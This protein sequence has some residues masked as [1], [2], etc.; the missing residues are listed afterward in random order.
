MGGS[1]ARGPLFSVDMDGPEQGKTQGRKKPIKS[2]G[3]YRIREKSER[4]FTGIRRRPAIGFFIMVG[5]V[6][7]LS[8]GSLCMAADE[9]PLSDSDPEPDDMIRI[10]ASEEMVWDAATDEVTAGEDVVI[11]RS[12]QKMT[13]GPVFLNLSTNEAT[14]TDGIRI[15]TEE[16]EFSGRQMAFNIDDETETLSAGTIYD[17]HLFYKKNHIHIRGQ[18]ITKTGEDTYEGQNV[19]VTSCEGES[20]AWEIGG[21]NFKVTYG[22]YG[23]VSHAFFRLHEVPVLY[24][25]FFVFPIKLERQT[26]LL[27]PSFDY[28][29]RKG[30]MMSQPFFW[31]INES[32]DATFYLDYMTKR[33]V[34]I[35]TEYRY[36][37]TDT[38]QGMVLFDF[39]DDRKVDDGTGTWGY[40]SDG[41]LRTNSDRYWFRMKH[42]QSL[43]EQSSL[44]LDLDIVSDQDYLYE[45]K[46]GNTGYVSTNARFLDTFGR[47]IDSYDETVRKNRLNYTSQWVGYSFTAE[48]IWRDNII[49]RT[50]EDTDDT[51]DPVQYLPTISFDRYR[52]SL[53]GSP[54]YAGFETDAAY[55]YH[56]DGISGERIDLNPRL[57]LPWNIGNVLSIEQSLGGRETLWQLESIDGEAELEETHHR[58]LYDFKTEFSS[59]IYHLFKPDWGEVDAMKHAVKFMVT[60]DY[61]PT[62]DQEGYPYFDGVDRIDG[63][64][65]ITYSVVNTFTTRKGGEEGPQYLQVVRLELSQSY[66]VDRERDGD[67][68]P[69]NPIESQLDVNFGSWGT[70]SGDAEWSTYTGD[71]V[72]RNVSYGV[73]DSRGD[74]LT[75]SHRYTA[76][77]VETFQGAAI[78]KLTDKIWLYPA[79]EQNLKDD[80]LVSRGLDLVY[81]GQCWSLGLIFEEEY[82]NATTT[83]K[84]YGLTV[85]FYGLGEVGSDSEHNEGLPSWAK[86]GF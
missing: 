6:L 32:S 67:S 5:A 59:D 44:M 7:L 74:K 57:Y 27:A 33:G 65:L 41:Y 3:T 10:T 40:S 20:P 46:R 15:T 34:K 19:V 39:L 23:F 68:E 71:F 31:A 2:K 63:E 56:E 14:A 64:N 86:E 24:T 28:S 12:G 76:S 22:G 60:Y 29:D 30:F 43:G 18:E 17:G 66:D 77:S 58:E 85:N 37:L 8:I 38:D 4:F 52:Q 62:V 9:T 42:D 78:L 72:S 1:G 51:E 48:A 35:G 83:D 75:L 55:L 54:L 13:S 25:P 81:R 50:Q 70:F 45:F 53:F 73:S 47:G 84:H 16:G 80:H 79:Y 36:V 49:A 61:T 11:E 26:G 69:F 82:E 21:K